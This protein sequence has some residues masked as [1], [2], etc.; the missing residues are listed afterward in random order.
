MGAED[1]G[2]SRSAPSRAAPAS[3]ATQTLSALP[4][5]LTRTI[6]IRAPRAWCSVIS[7]TRSASPR[8]GAPVRASIRVPG[9]AVLIRYPNAVVARGTVEHIVPDERIVFTYG[10]EDPAKP[11]PPGGS[12]VTIAL[13]DDDDGTRLDLLHELRRSRPCVITTCPAGAISSPCS[14]T[15]SQT[16]RMPTPPMPSIDSSPPGMK[17]MQPRAV[18][19]RRH[20]RSSRGVSRR[21]CSDPRRRRAGR[22]HRRAP[23]A[24]AA[25]C[26]SSGY[27][28]SA[29]PRVPCLVDWAAAR[30][31]ETTARGTNFFEFTPAGRVGCVFGFW[32]G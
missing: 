28:R 10:Y 7:R 26:G 2:R 25:E 4:H 29:T 20:C 27:L 12:R 17:P 5:S 14:P 11:I 16:K 19:P 18:R 9:G 30:G 21:L 22:A 24:H 6:V 15:S 32:S 8:G 23:H 1:P 31:G 13:V 3:P